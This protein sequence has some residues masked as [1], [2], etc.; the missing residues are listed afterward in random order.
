MDMNAMPWPTLVSSGP[1][2]MGTKAPGAEVP[3]PA[4]EF[5]ELEKTFLIQGRSVVALQDVNVAIGKNEFVSIVGPSGCGKSTLML[6]A[7]GLETPTKGQVLVNGALVSRPVTDLGVVF[8]KDVL[9][10]WRTVFGNI[11]LQADVRGLPREP[12]LARAHQLIERVGLKEFKDA[13]PWQLSGGMRQRVAIC[14][15]LLHDTSLLIMDEPFGALDAFTRD[16]MIS[17]LQRIWLENPRTALFITHDIAE[18]VFLSDRVIVMSARPGAIV[19]EIR[20][21]LRRPRDIS[22]RESSEFVDY[23]RQIRGIFRALEVIP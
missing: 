17:D 6:L 14:R 23:Q 11:M 2:N 13:Y 18:A 1:L 8:Q 19:A 3:G 15:A 22:I 10:D 20:I 5:C 16:Q 7:A 21:E 12:A 9:F 4:I